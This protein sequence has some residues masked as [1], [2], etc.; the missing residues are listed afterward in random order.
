MARS[1]ERMVR[2]SG[3]YRAR[4]EER[5]VARRPARLRRDFSCRVNSGGTEVF[6]VGIQFSAMAIRMSQPPK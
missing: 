5:A 3:S 2:R 4:P 6:R 1:L